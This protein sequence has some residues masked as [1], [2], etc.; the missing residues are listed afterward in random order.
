MRRNRAW[1]WLLS[2]HARRLRASDARRPGA[3]TPRRRARRCRP[4]SR[5]RPPA[6]AAGPP[7]SRR[8]GRRARGRTAASRRS[9]AARGSRP[10]RRRCRTPSPGPAPTT[11]ADPRRRRCGRDASSP[12][13]P[14]DSRTNSTLPRRPHLRDR[15]RNR[16]GAQP[17][18]AGHQH[19][20]VL[21]Q[22]RAAGQRQR[23]QRRRRHRDRRAA[24]AVRGATSSTSAGSR[25]AGTAS[26]TASACQRAPSSSTRSQPRPRG[27][28]R[29]T[30]TCAQRTPARRMSSSSSTRVAAVDGAEHRPGDRRRQRL[31]HR[32]GQVRRAAVQRRGQRRGGRAQADGGRRP[33]VHA[34]Q[35]RVDR[36]GHHLLAEPVAD[37]LGDRRIGAGTPGRTAGCVRRPCAR[38]SRRRPARPAT[39]RC[40]GMPLQGACGNGCSRP[41]L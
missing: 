6:S 37:Q 29:S 40:A 15:Q 16:L 28:T 7:A 35:Q 20:G 26:T 12:N 11:P 2:C 31:A 38:S 9:S 5:P 3:P 25:G 36:A 22:R 17:F 41:W 10:A 24:A 8:P 4:G 39:T 19:P 18:S 13:R 32:V 23:H 1:P 21:G 34:G 27:S 30:A 14:N 33:G